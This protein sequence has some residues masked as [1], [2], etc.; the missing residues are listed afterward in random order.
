[1][2]TR[3]PAKRLAVGGGEHLA[4]RPSEQ[5]LELIGGERH[6][7]RARL[8]H[9]RRL[10]AGLGHQVEDHDVDAAV[11]RPALSGRVRRARPELAVAGGREPVGGDRRFADEQRH[12]R[13]ARAVESSQFDAK[14]AVRIGASSVCPSTRTA[15]GRS[16]MAP[17]IRRI[18]SP[19]GR[20]QHRLARFERRRLGHRHDQAAPVVDELQ[21]SGDDVVVQGLGQPLAA[22]RAADRRP[23]VARD[24]RD[25]AACG[26][27]VSTLRRRRRRRRR[28]LGL[29]RADQRRG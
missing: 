16:A 8:L 20:R 17:P 9:G 26:T 28:R 18:V 15:L 4:E 24:L 25:A 23:A 2:S 29:R 3:R 22:A 12:H 14:R 13:V 10:L 1:M 21:A 27:G 6:A 11:A 7:H 19:R 5:R